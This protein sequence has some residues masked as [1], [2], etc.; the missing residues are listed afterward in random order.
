MNEFVERRLKKENGNK[1]IHIRHRIDLIRIEEGFYDLITKEKEFI[2][3]FD[4][5]QYQIQIEQ[6]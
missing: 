4:D 2:I 5:N 6:N 3:G 1:A